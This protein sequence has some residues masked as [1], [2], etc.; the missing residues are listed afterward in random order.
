MSKRLIV[1]GGDAAGMSAASTAKRR[2]G[3]DLEVLVFERGTRTSYSACG[4]PYWIGGEVDGPEALIA[5]TPE[6]HR[7]NEI[8]VRIRSEV[9]AIDTATRTVTVRSDDTDSSHEYDHLL[10]ATGA[11]PIRPNL[12]GIDAGGVLGVQSLDD[13]EEIVNALKAGPERIVVVGSG[14]IGLELA[15]ACVRRGF[16]TTVV[17]QSATSMGTLDSDLGAKVAEAMS[18]LGINMQMSTRVNEFSTDITG[19]VSGVVTDR[20]AIKADL[21][22]LG[23]GVR[24]RTALARDA[25]LPI[26]DS[27]AIKVDERQRA[28]A[29]PNIWAAGDCVESYHRILGTSLHVPLGT[30][31]NKQGLV[32]GHNIAAEVLGVGESTTFRGI[33]GTAVTKVCNLEIART[34]LGEAEARDAG[35]DVAATSIETTTKAG[36]LADAKPMTVKM[37]VDRRSRKVLGA[38]IVGEEGSALRIDTVATALW[39]GMTVDDVMFSD[40]AYA[41]PFS[42]VWDPIQVAARSLVSKLGR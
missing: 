38:Q 39:A 21:V 1:I 6:Q 42:S 8:D 9:I 35:F 40:L 14:Y 24:G 25:G 2:A 37:V 4:I 17:D 28:D 26:G 3:D 41:P 10:I 15:E 12:P 11:E 20:G 23:I 32:A 13:G 16:H 29:E 5:R 36:Y 19:R 31:A 27:G 33:V 18:G 30:H 22:L 34:G 7:A